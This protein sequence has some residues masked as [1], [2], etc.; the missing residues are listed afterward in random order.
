MK[1]REL[2]QRSAALGWI[3]AFPVSARAAS[4]LGGDATP[5]PLVP[6]AREAVPVAFLVSDGAVVIDFCGP[7]EVF[8]DAI[9]SGR[10]ADAFKLY[11][12]AETT[13]PITASG[14]LKIVPDYT[15]E[16]APAPKVIVIPAQGGHTEK[17]IDWVRRASKTTD[18]TM[19]VCTGAFLLAET[20]L[21]SGK[22]ATTH[23]SSYKTFAM[24]F[25]DVRVNRGARFV[26]EGNL[27][28]AG[29][30][31]S[32]IDLALR[33]VQRYYGRDAA[34]QT[35]FQMEY[36]GQGWLRADSNEVYARERVSTAEQPLCPIC[37][38][39][40]DPKTAPHSV[41]R[42]KDYY[43]CSADHKA[44]FDAAPA[45]FASEP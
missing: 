3:A 4:V 16:K 44:S 26:E 20:G 1:R 2:L 38:M 40:V 22:S 15:F 32:G 28:S 33:V 31:S 24:A 13:R 6:P 30:L 43:F 10:D 29:G 18:V 37:D 9:V 21:L 39:D 35:A 27:A 12:V 36:Q 25:P 41:Y 5:M 7:W 45:K 17:A 23:H 11:T 42:G 14:G 8:Q 34:D 19:S